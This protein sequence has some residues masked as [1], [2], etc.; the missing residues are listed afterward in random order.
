MATQAAHLAPSDSSLPLYRMDV[1]TF[2]QLVEVP[3]PA[4]GVP[5]L[6]VAWLFEGLGD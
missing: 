1:G 5:D 3:P 6:D 2:D 4:E